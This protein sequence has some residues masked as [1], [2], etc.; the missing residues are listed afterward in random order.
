MPINNESLIEQRICAELREVREAAGVT[1]GQIADLFGWERAAVHKMESGA[2][3]V[4]LAD[5]L[6][7][8]RYLR[9]FVPGHPALALFDHFSKPK[10]TKA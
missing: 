2:V 3:R 5:Y 4:R 10:R 8:M 6:A 9:D 7:I 1:Q